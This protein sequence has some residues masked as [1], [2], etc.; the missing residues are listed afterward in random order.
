MIATPP[1]DWAPPDAIAGRVARLERLRPDHAARLWPALE[2]HGEVWRWLFEGPFERAADHAALI[3][4]QAASA[5]PAFY[6]IHDGTA[7]TGVAS[8]MRIDRAQG[9]IEIGNVCL[10]PALQRTTAAT[11]ALA[12]MAGAAFDA[13]FRRLEWK[14]NARNGPSRRAA[15]RLG[16]AYEGTFRQHMI[17]K[18]AS[19]DTAWYAILDAE[20]PAIRAVLAA[21]LDGA[22]AG[23]QP[24]ALSARMVEAVAGLGRPA[25]P[26]PSDPPA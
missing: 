22:A 2:G 23:A 1:A 5:D 21:W 15:R 16:Y 8:L 12:A 17:V 20:W 6:A 24:F 11:D 14:C 9:T 13:G 19:R 4:R 25:V 7:W 3:A 10:P 18:G 26:D